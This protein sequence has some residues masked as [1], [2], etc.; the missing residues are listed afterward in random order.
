METIYL[1]IYI[2]IFQFLFKLS[3]TYIIIPFTSEMSK[4]PNN[5]LPK[6]L[7]DKIIFNDLYTNINI[8]TPSQSLKFN[9]NFNSYH[10]YILTYKQL[11]Q[12]EQY[13]QNISSTYILYNNKSI[14]FQGNEF[15]TAFNS[16][17]KITIGKYLK[18]YDLEFLLIKEENS[19]T[20][21][22]FAG[23]LGF[24]VVDIGEPTA[25]T[26]GLIY[27]LNNQK[28][29][30]NH[31]FT[32]IFNKN[33]NYEGNII[34]G[35][36][37]YEKYID[38]YYHHGYC[39]IDMNYDYHWGW[40]DFE[41]IMKGNQIKLYYVYLKP[42][43]G[44]IIASNQFKNLLKKEFFEQKINEKKCYESNA[45]YDF[46]Y[47]DDDVD[48][49]IESFKFLNKKNNITFEINKDD[50]VYSYYG[51]KYFLMVFN[52]NL[53]SNTIYL[54]IPFLKKYDIIFDQDSRHV[55]F[56]NFKID[57]KE[58]DIENKNNDDNKKIIPEEFRKKDDWKIILIIVMFII[59]LLFIFL[60]FYLYR[61]MRRKQ[62]KAFIAGF[63]YSEI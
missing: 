2:L 44:V 33:N 58:E 38:D 25:L 45:K 43:N 56:Y 3:N 57:F 35:K 13:N 20:K 24:K 18:D 12:F 52:K 55:G 42:E 46:F 40:S 39:I 41:V 48:I 15:N 10:T 51:K 19:D 23:S 16:S 36:N 9:I 28:L 61:D 29:I 49:N 1:L 7:M 5:L 50:L 6:D 4:I 27:K 63:E 53:M 26:A 60:I 31:K 17:D 32:L 62:V 54:G 30:D 21:I 59:I 37:I 47:C 8:G 22:T 11:R 14:F 34:L